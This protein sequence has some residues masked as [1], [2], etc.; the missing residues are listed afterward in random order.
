MIMGGV[1]GFLVPVTNGIYAA[2]G[3]MFA[4]GEEASIQKGLRLYEQVVFVMTTILYSVVLSAILPFVACYTD[5]ITDVDY[6]RPAFVYVY[7][8]AQLFR[9]Y[10]FPYSDVVNAAGHFRQMRNPAFIEAVINIALSVALVFKFGIIGVAVGSL[11]AYIYR[12]VRYAYYMSKHVAVRSMTPFFKR[13]GLSGATI[14][15]I[16]LII[17]LIPFPV[18]NN[19]FVWL[20]NCV[21]MM[22]FSIIIVT[23][24]EIIFYRRDLFRLIAMVKRLFAKKNPSA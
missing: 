7:V 4:K 18:A 24:V 20:S 22:I 19:Y 2:F 13:V 12:T 17:S 16:T 21:T 15:L 6:I 10:R 23:L 3:N 8:A 5:G 9:C 1:Y 14:I 11:V